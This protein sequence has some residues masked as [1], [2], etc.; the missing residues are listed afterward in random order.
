MVFIV[1]ILDQNLE[2]SF[3]FV[4]VGFG[5]SVTD[6]ASV[7]TV[8]TSDEFPNKVIVDSPRMWIRFQS[9][10]SVTWTGIFLQIQLISNDITGNHGNCLS[11]PLN[12][13]L[14]ILHEFSFCIT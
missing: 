7:L 14:G 6:D 9:D 5:T 10:H 2:T 1:H 4:K 8:L 3:D 13:Q 11:K 12:F